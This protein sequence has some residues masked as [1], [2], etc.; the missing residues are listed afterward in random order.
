MPESHSVRSM[1]GRIAGRYDVA[2]RVL[3]GGTDIYWRWRLTGLVRS[4]QPDSVADLATGSGDVAFAL[5]RRLGTGVRISG[6][7]FCPPML[8]EARV[9]GARGAMYKDIPFA[10]GDCLALPIDDQSVAAVTIS[11]GLRNL[12]NRHLGLQEMRRI[13]K[14]GGCLYCLEFSQPYALLRP[15]YYLYLKY[16]LPLFARLLTGDKAA[17]DYLAGSI[18]SF[19]PGRFKRRNAFCRIQ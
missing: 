11:F 16:V 6:Y 18:E 13:L 5:R 9:K 15:F 1:F 12:E 8:E 2:N 4:Q 7:D 19:P 10:E 17:Y 14:P 3:S